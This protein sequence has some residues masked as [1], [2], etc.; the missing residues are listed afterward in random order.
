MIN[1]HEEGGALLAEFD[2]VG[3]NGPKTTRIGMGFN[4]ASHCVCLYQE[5]GDERDELDEDDMVVLDVEAQR[6]LYTI[7]KARFEDLADP[8]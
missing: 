7:L 5:N 1:E 8:R 6:T 4:K 3:A 2:S